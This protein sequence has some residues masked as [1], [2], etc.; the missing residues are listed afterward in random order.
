[1]TDCYDVLCVTLLRCVVGDRLSRFVVY[2]KLLEHRQSFRIT[3]YFTHLCA[4]IGFDIICN[5]SVCGDGS[6]ETDTFSLQKLKF[7][8][9]GSA[10]LC[11][12][13]YSLCFF[14]SYNCFTET[15]GWHV[16]WPN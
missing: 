9:K 6:C 3:L 15:I 14:P 7:P 1:M 13:Y 10:D 2:G 4:Y 5:F 8:V 16:G 12:S 11:H